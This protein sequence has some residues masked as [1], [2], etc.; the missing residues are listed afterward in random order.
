[1]P[2]STEISTLTISAT[3]IP[4]STEISTVTLSATPLPAVT[5]TTTTTTTAT[6]SASASAGASCPTGDVV[7]NPSFENVLAG[8]WT[9]FA[10]SLDTTIDNG[11]T[12]GASGTAKALRVRITATNANLPQRIVQ[13]ISVCPGT[14]YQFSGQNKRATTAGNISLIAFVVTSAGTTQLAGGVVTAATWTAMPL[15]NSGTFTAMSTSALLYLEVT[16]TSGTGQAKE[17]DIDEIHLT[18]I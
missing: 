5:E 8:S 15:A 18:P 4:A 12:G 14:T 10:S 13:A 6:I 11:V 7:A 16:F 2:A 9:V 3:P 1:M 17:V